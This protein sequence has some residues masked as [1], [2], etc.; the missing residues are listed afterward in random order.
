MTPATGAKKAVDRAGTAG[1][2]Q[3]RPDEVR[4]DARQGAG[5][6][7]GKG[8]D[9]DRP[10]RVEVDRQA[11]GVTIR[12]PTAMLIAMAT[13]MRARVAVEKS[14]ERMATMARRTTATT[15]PRR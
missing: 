12:A 4:E 13:G 1:D 14:R 15:S 2:R 10:D 11:Q 9:E 7:S 6:R 3:D 5:P 8:A